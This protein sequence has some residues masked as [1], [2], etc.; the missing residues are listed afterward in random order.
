MQYFY[1]GQLTKDFSGSCIETVRDRLHLCIRDLP[2]IR[3]LREVLAYQAIRVFIQA[4]LPGMARPGE[5]EVCAGF[6]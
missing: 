6:L 5:E 4:A 3:S 2:E 1:Q